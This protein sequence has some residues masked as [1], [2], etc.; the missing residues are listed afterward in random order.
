MNLKPHYTHEDPQILHVGTCPDRSYYI[1][2]ADEKEA[3]NGL[4]ETR[5]PRSGKNIDKPGT[6]PET[7]R[8]F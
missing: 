1:P 5:M 7:R 2:F 6:F 8:R 3:E 4:S